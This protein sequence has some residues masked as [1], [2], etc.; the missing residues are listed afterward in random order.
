MA[1][2]NANTSTEN[3]SHP[4]NGPVHDRLN[5]SMRKTEKSLSRIGEE[6]E[7]RY[8]DLRDR[9]DEMSEQSAKVVRNHP[10]YSILG[11]AAVGLVFG[12]FFQARRG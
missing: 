9:L 1:Q 4:M 2:T 5:D 8:H 11:A 7:S 10:F 3:R 6:I 12:M